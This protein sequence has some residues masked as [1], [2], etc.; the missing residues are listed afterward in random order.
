M[1]YSS[2]LVILAFFPLYILIIALNSTTLTRQLY[3]FG[4]IGESNSIA[5]CS[6]AVRV[7]ADR[8]QENEAV[9]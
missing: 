7:T 3:S 4:V 5:Y 8:S 2:Q 6:E 9:K 1:S